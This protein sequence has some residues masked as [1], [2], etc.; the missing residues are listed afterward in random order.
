MEYETPYIRELRKQGVR[1]PAILCQIRT[2][3]GRRAQS[4]GIDVFKG[5]F[6]TP[7]PDRLCNCLTGV[8]KDNLIMKKNDND[9]ENL[10]YHEHPTKE[11]LL[12]YFGQRIRVRKM[13][14]REAFRLQDC[15]DE[16]IEKIQA[17]PFKTY[18]EREASIKKAD[19]K[20]LARIKRESIAKTRQYALA[21]NSIT[22]SVLVN[23]FRTMFLDNQPENQQKRIVQPSLF[24][25][26]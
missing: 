19:K 23:I 1:L 6:L 2:D 20:E 5:K 10:T 12:E 9:M 18:A 11:D 15:S 22:I 17:Y 8:Q 16:D 21:G 26:L 13:T 24:D 14:P 3:E 25:N 4:N 7:R